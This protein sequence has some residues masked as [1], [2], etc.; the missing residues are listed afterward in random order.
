MMA[1]YGDY[2]LRTAYLLLKDRQSAEEAVQDAFVAA[3]RHIDQLNDAAKLKSWLTA[4]TVNRCRMRMRTWSWR[5]LIPFDVL[6][7][8]VSEGSE[9]EPE[10]I[11]LRKIAG[12]RLSDAIHKLDYPYRE[13]IA[14]YY[15]NEWSVQEIADHLHMNPNTVKARLARGRQ[16]LRRIYE[17]EGKGD[18]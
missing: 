4:I 9:E 17:E 11:V 7:R 18:E 5:H 1:Q 14:L 10:E 15:F 3:Y 8:S 16:R 2:L 12:K 13:A 6:S